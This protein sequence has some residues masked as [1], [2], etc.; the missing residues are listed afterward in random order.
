M[1]L[2]VPSKDSSWSKLLLY[3][4]DS[5]HAHIECCLWK[6]MHRSSSQRRAKSTTKYADTDS[7]AS[8]VR[9]IIIAH[10]E[11]HAIKICR[12]HLHDI[13][14]FSIH[15]E[16]MLVLYLQCT[17]HTFTRNWN[18]SPGLHFSYK[19]YYWKARALRKFRCDEKYFSRTIFIFRLDPK[20]YN[21]KPR[22]LY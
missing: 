12:T 6:C 4:T 17:V 18:T 8:A 11:R 3:F 2:G 20:H 19:F 1:S 13:T 7:T 5:Q 15:I 16:W 9:K 10:I 14:Q 22:H 21:W